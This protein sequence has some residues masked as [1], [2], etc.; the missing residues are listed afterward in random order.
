MGKPGRV[1]RARH[2]SRRRLL[3]LPTGNERRPLVPS[4]RVPRSN[5][6]AC[7]GPDAARRG[8]RGRGQPIT[9]CAPPWLTEARAS[10]YRRFLDPAQRRFVRRQKKRNETL[11]AGV[12]AP[13][14]RH[15]RRDR[16]GSGRRSLRTVSRGR[17]VD[18]DRWASLRS[19]HTAAAATSSPDHVHVLVRG[20]IRASGPDPRRGLERTGYATSLPHVTYL[21]GAAVSAALALRHRIGCGVSPSRGR[22]PRSSSPSG[23]AH[24]DHHIDD[25]DQGAAPGPPFEAADSAVPQ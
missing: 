17:S 23:R 24:D 1:A 19:T 18:N 3:P 11:N 10:L 20:H 9:V 25:D 13:K 22:V 7:R 6:P 21:Q 12:L 2:A 4:S 15:P 8:F 16:L 5:F 14:D